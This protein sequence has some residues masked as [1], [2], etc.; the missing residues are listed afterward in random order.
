[1]GRIC[2]VIT[3]ESLRV[4]PDKW[5]TCTHA[6]WHKTE[7]EHQQNQETK[8]RVIPTVYQ[9]NSTPIL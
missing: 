2:M 6:P 8:A 3:F 7:W 5:L 4:K 1:M 9:R